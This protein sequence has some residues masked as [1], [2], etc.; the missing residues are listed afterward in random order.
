MEAERSR[1]LATD[2]HASRGENGLILVAVPCHAVEV[3]KLA[4]DR[5]LEDLLM[6]LDAE[7]QKV[8]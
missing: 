8:R 6:T 5:V 2:K 7:D 4:E 1:F 3:K